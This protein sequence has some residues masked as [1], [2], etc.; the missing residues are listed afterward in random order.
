MQ[1]CWSPRWFEAF[2]KLTHICNTS[3]NHRIDKS[4]LQPLANHR[5]IV[6]EASRDICGSAFIGIERGEFWRNLSTLRRAPSSRDLRDVGSVCLLDLFI[7]C[8]C[9]SAQIAKDFT[10][11]RRLADALKTIERDRTCHLNF[12]GV[13]LDPNIRDLIFLC[14]HDLTGLS[15][16]R[17]VFGYGSSRMA[18]NKSLRFEPFNFRTWIAPFSYYDAKL[19]CRAA[20]RI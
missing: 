12:F 4:I 16:F 9:V 19:P 8:V 2:P 11:R 15:N 14:R 1:Q 5:I 7:S 3:S 17:L 13:S 6:E 20:E 10:S 18:A